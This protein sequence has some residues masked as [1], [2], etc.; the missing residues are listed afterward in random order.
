VDKELAASIAALLN[1]ILAGG[2]AGWLAALA[3]IVGVPTFSYKLPELIR[4]ISAYHNTHRKTTHMIAQEKLKME[5]ATSEKNERTA[6]PRKKGGR[7]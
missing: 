1:K 6:L 4:A 2:E 7:P 3:I 5:K